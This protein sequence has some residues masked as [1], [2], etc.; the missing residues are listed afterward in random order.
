MYVYD[1]L[2][3]MTILFKNTRQNKFII[4]SEGLNIYFR[5]A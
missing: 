1:I 2:F 4:K 3:K 5:A